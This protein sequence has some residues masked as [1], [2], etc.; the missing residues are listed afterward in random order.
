MKSENAKVDL[1]FVIKSVEIR[2][3]TN[4]WVKYPGNLYQDQDTRTA[5]KL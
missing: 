1:V 4:E 3:Y 5:R 2:N